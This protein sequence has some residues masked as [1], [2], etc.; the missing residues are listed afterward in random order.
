MSN[1]SITSNTYTLVTNEPNVQIS[2]L[3]E[4]DDRTIVG[5]FIESARCYENGSII[6]P[7]FMV[8]GFLKGKVNLEKHAFSF[9]TRSG[10]CDILPDGNIL[11]KNR[12]AP[13]SYKRTQSDIAPNEH[14]VYLRLYPDG[15]ATVHQDM[16]KLGLDQIVNSYGLSKPEESK[17]VS[18]QVT[19]DSIENLSLTEKVQMLK[20]IIE[21]VD[22][23]ALTAK[24]GVLLTEATLEQLI[25]EIQNRK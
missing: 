12:L 13:V 1:Q 9:G 24:S 15:S 23:N 11:I 19:T 6:D 17:I 22:V 18:G 16:K 8:K 4:V 7:H 21:T 25:S 5:V 3:P 2:N 10:L 14:S 20:S